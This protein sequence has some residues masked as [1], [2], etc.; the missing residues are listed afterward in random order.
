MNPNL[1][2]F[3]PGTCYRTAAAAVQLLAAA[4]SKS[5]VPDE[6]SLP[7]K[8]TVHASAEAT[9]TLLGD[10]HSVVWS[11]GDSFRLFGVGDLSGQSFLLVE[12]AGTA[13]GTFT[14]NRPAGSSFVALYPENHAE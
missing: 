7:G 1:H 6:G 5:D 14:G 2:F 8:M 9:R 10:N 13:S 12:G 3:V 11:E 4:C